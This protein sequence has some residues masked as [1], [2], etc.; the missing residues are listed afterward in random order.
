MIKISRH[1]FLMDCFELNFEYKFV[2]HENIQN[3]N[4][5]IK[6]SLIKL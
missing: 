3:L 4:M 2:L 6:S 1:T 5:Q